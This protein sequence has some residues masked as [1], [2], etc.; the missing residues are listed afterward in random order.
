MIELTVA[1]PIFNSKRIAWAALEGLCNQRE[2]DFQWELLIMEEQENEFGLSEVAK[3]ADRLK[4]VG[5]VSL[6][7]FALYYRISLPQ[8]WRD[9]GEKAAET[10]KVF[11]L[12]AADCYAE[13]L[14]LRKSLDA[15]KAGYEWIQNRRGYYYSIHYKMLIEFDQESF[16][17]G[18]KTGLN[19]A[20]ATDK[21]RNLP[22]SYI[23]SGVDNWL[24]RVTAPKK[25]LWIE[26]ETLG[27]V[28]VD[29]L[30]NISFARRFLFHHP[31][32]PMV[33]TDKTIYDIV[34]KEIAD[35]L[36]KLT[37]KENVHTPVH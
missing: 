10:S 19:M 37:I 20:I 17:V 7:Y 15:A 26:G 18:C 30:N 32:P 1:L 4:S 31:K 27:G 12:Q 35:R 29:G 36:S 3:Y 9:L 11:L 21:V 22:V 25:V 23:T 14:R 5:C 8:K 33:K 16:G 13:P 6:K 34:P 2:I 28:D 24:Y